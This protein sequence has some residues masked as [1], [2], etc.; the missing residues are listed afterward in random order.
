MVGV[1]EGQAGRVGADAVAGR[2]AERDRVRPAQGRG[3]RR[4]AQDC[5]TLQAFQNQHL[6]DLL[7]SNVAFCVI[8]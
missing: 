7:L 1:G 6:D 3:D 8:C 4:V 2:A 5:L